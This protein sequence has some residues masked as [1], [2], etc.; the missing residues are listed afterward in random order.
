M[1]K[2]RLPGGEEHRGTKKK[3]THLRLGQTSSQGGSIR[4]VSQIFT[5]VVREQL[6]GRISLVVQRR[7][8]ILADRRLDTQSDIDFLHDVTKWKKLR[9]GMA[10]NNAHLAGERTRSKKKKEKKRDGEESKGT[11]RQRVSG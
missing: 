1:G 10:G 9:G 6:G 5:K 2:F 8:L 11:V 7:K 3:G 4:T